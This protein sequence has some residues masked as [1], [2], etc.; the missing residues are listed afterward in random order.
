MKKNNSDPVSYKINERKALIR[1]LPFQDA[2]AATSAGGGATLRV[3]PASLQRRKLCRPQPPQQLTTE[4]MACNICS[5]IQ[6][7]SIITMKAWYFI[8][9]KQSARTRRT[10]LKVLFASA[11][12]VLMPTLDT[13]S[14]VG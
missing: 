6:K 8:T 9:T 14:Q 12:M 1:D 5:T 2:A 10:E 7:A 3:C 11:A 13:V 4:Q